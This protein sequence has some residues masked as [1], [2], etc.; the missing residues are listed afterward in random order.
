MSKADEF[1]QYAEEALRAAA[2]STSDQEQQTLVK[3]A[4]LWSQAALTADPVAAPTENN[5]PI[6]RLGTEAQPAPPDSS[7]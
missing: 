3:L 2:K 4:R 5:R 1:R 6:S 7:S